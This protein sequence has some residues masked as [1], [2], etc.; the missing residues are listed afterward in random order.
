MAG[1]VSGQRSGETAM[2]TT[3]HAT[4]HA[5]PVLIDQRPRPACACASTPMLGSEDDEEA[6][7][8]KEAFET[9]VTDATAKRM[10]L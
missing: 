5:G 7:L 6:S 2:A 3:A 1:A 8:G 9:D 4:A 10:G